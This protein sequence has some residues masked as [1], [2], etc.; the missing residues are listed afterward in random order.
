M[1]DPWWPHCKHAKSD[2]SDLLRQRAALSQTGGEAIM[3][4]R[5]ATPPPGG[6]RVQHADLGGDHLHPG[7]GVSGLEEQ[8]MLL[9]RHCQDLLG[10]LL[11][12]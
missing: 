7:G 5:R 12:V 3:D 4:T 2:G 10:H 1:R 6:A 11:D 8:E 9:Q